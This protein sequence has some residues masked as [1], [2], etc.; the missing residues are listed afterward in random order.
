MGWFSKLFGGG[1]SA[2]REPLAEVWAR[3]RPRVLP[4]AKPGIR[5]L[6][7]E[8]PT[9]C[10][11]GGAPRV[12]AAFEWPMRGER[13]LVF[14]A[15]LD[16]AALAAAHRFDWLPDRGSLAFFYDV[17]EMPWGFDPNDRGAWC[18]RF[19]EDPAVE[20][21]PPAPL[22]RE[23]TLHRK[24][25]RPDRFESFPAADSDAAEGLD[26]S[27]REWDAYGDLAWGADEDT[28]HHQVGGFADPVQGDTMELECQLAS[29]G[30]DCGGSEGFTSARAK[31]LEP[32][33][34]AWRLLLQ[35]DSDDDVGVMWGDLGRIYFWVREEESREGRFDGVWLVLQCG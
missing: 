28:P 25:V 16:L 14:V 1:G 31:E 12:A 27:D 3:I 22:P 19:V 18:V 17:D 32:G 29:N 20:P 34:S 15:Q 4:L 5:L 26:F 13:P 30:V 6:A 35:V 33:A 23:L 11:I 2:R 24:Y 21:A 7:S 10:W 9:T 8:T